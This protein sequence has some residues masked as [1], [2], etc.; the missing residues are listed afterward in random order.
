MLPCLRAS[1]FENR[2][3]SQR[4]PQEV[5]KKLQCECVSLFENRQFFQHRPQEVMQKNATM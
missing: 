2:K 3:F 1:L 5:M 4:R